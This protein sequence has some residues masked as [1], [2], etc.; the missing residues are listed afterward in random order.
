MTQT[1]QFGMNRF[2]MPKIDALVRKPD[3]ST[4]VRQSRERRERLMNGNFEVAGQEVTPQH[5]RQQLLSKVQGAQRQ[6]LVAMFNGFTAQRKSFDQLF[7][8]IDP[9]TGKKTFDQ[10]REAI[11][12]E[13][14]LRKRMVAMIQNSNAL[15]LLH[16]EKSMNQRGPQPVLNKA[17]GY[18]SSPTPTPFG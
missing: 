13:H 10:I 2:A 15:Q 8:D 6:Q 18:N 14:E 1:V 16:L 9:A 7:N 4:W 12:N 3:T 5:Q 11:G 17:P